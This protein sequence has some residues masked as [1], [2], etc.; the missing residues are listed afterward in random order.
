MS[1]LLISGC[2]KPPADVEKPYI[3]M[4]DVPRHSTVSVRLY[5]LSEQDNSYAPLMSEVT[6]AAGSTLERA[7]IE[8]LMQQPESGF[9]PVSGAGWRLN[10]VDVLRNYNQNVDQSIAFIDISVPS[11]L[12]YELIPTFRTA[13]AETLLQ[14]NRVDYLMLTVNGELP[15]GMGGVISTSTGEGTANETPMLLYYPNAENNYAIPIVRMVVPEDTSKDKQVFNELKKSSEYNLLDRM[16]PSNIVCTGMEAQAD[17]NMLTVHLSGP[18]S[19]LDNDPAQLTLWNRCFALSLLANVED[20]SVVT[21]AFKSNASYSSGSVTKK[22]TYSIEPRH[23]NPSTMERGFHDDTSTLTGIKGGFVQLYLADRE[24]P[25][26]L[27]TQRVCS[28]EEAA[29]PYTCIT[30]MLKG[31]QYDEARNMNRVAPDGVDASDFIECWIYRD[32]VVVNLTKRFFDRCVGIGEHQEL[33]LTYAITN[34]LT[35]YHA[36]K[37]VQFVREG[38]GVED[39]AGRIILSQTLLRNPGIIR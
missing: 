9:L 36:I 5:Y 19:F 10:S 32:T 38:V 8:A 13:C 21:I 16:Y 20:K 30:E 29:N 34:A 14:L 7:A 11:E 17:S 26:L 24:T 4:K 35:D 25:S 31:P 18:G 28:F 27:R 37:Q 33:L 6:V 22:W 39:M 23:N 3:S 15:R 2:E 12:D 1:C